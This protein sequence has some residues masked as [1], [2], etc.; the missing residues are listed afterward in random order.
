MVVF[1]N[2]KLSTYIHISIYLSNYLSLT[3]SL[4]IY[5]S[6]YLSI[7][8]YLYT[9]IYLYIHISISLLDLVVVD[10]PGPVPVKHLEGLLHLIVSDLGGYS[11]VFII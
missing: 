3:L 9:Y 11:Q 5:I 8:I 6:I 2:W 4:S 10:G 7:Y 1:S